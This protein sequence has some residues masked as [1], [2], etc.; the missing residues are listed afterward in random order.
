MTT[1]Q[2]HEPHVPAS[3]RPRRHRTRRRVLVLG[4]CVLVLPILLFL[5]LTHSPLTSA[6]VS[7]ILQN[8]TGAEVSV[9]DARIGIRGKATLR[10]VAATAPGLRG[11]A[12]TFVQ[13]ERIVAEFSWLDLL[14]GRGVRAITL[15][16][17]RLRL[18]QSTETQLLNV[19]ALTLLRP[20]SSG[21]AGLPTVIVD[22]ASLEIGEHT[23]ADYNPLSVIHFDGAVIPDP[24]APNNASTIR[25]S[26][27]A[28]EGPILGVPGQDIIGRIDNDAVTITPTE[29]SL[30]SLRPSSLPASAR[31]ELELLDLKGRL[32]L[33]AFTYTFASGRVEAEIVLRGVEMNL[34]IQPVGPDHPDTP[35]RLS[36]VN[37]TVG[38]RSDGILAD[39]KG[40]VADLPYTVR[41]NYMGSTA[42][43]PFTCELATDGYQV[44]SR[45]DLLPFAPAVVRERLDTFSNPTATVSTHLTISRDLP[46]PD[47]PSP[48]RVRGT[49]DFKD[50]TASYHEFPYVF[51]QMT[52][53]VT[54]DDEKIVLNSV[55]GV[56]DSG[57]RIHVTGTVAPPTELATV[58]IVARVTNVP[59]DQAIANAL[60]PE[61]DE[62]IS[63]LFSEGRH[64]QLVESGLVLGAEQ[65]ARLKDD[66][67]RLRAMPVRSPEADARLAAVEQTLARTPAF[68]PGG[69]ADVLVHVTRPY[70]YL[71]PWK[72]DVIVTFVSLGVLPEAF[73][74]PIIASDVRLHITDDHA[75]LE[76]GTYRTPRGG[77]AT[78][79][80]TVDL[81]APDGSRDFLPRIEIVA[82]SIPVDD[83]LIHAIPDRS[84][85][86]DSN[87]SAREALTALDIDG[88]IDI[89]AKI[90]PRA[91]GSLGYAVDAD[92]P[93]LRAAP[94]G[95]PDGPAIFLD[96]VRG[97]LSISD[98][99]L[100][101]S[102]QASLSAA[103][104]AERP[105]DISP[106]GAASVDLGV[107]LGDRTGSTLTASVTDLNAAAPIED[108]IRPFSPAA[109]ERLAS[110]R[111]AHQPK[112]TLDVSITAQAS[113]DASRAVVTARNIRDAS[114]DAL[115]GRVSLS[116]V[117][118]EVVADLDAPRGNGATIGFRDFVGAIDH[119]AMSAGRIALGGQ[120]H[121]GA[122]AIDPSR[123]DLSIEWTDAPL[124]SDAVRSLLRQSVGET[125]HSLYAEHD[126][127][128]RFDLDLRLSPA[129]RR[130]QDPPDAPPTL[131]A[132]GS[133][134]PRTISVVRYGTR[135]EFPSASG[136]IRFSP[137]G[138]TFDRLSLNAPGISLSLDGWWRLA[139]PGEGHT[140]ELTFNGWAT[141]QGR[142]VSSLLPA[143]LHEMAESAEFAVDGDL[144]LDDVRL[145]V[146]GDPRSPDAD[147]RATGAISLERASMRLGL[148][149]T[150]LSGV[151]RFM[152]GTEAGSPTFDVGLI[153][154][155]L[156]LANL[157]IT[158]ARV[159]VASDPS[160]PRVIVP[161]ISGNAHGGRLSGRAII[162]PTSDNAATRDFYASLHVAGARFA[163]VLADIAPG[164]ATT[165]S[166]PDASRGLL[167]AEFTMRGI[168][169]RPETT[170]GR[171]EF[172]VSGGKVL[173]L[174]LLLPI[175]Q[176]TSL[177]VPTAEP[178][179]LALASFHLSDGRVVFEEMSVFSRSVELFG[180]GTMSWPDS[181][182]DLRIISRAARSLPI[183]SSI[184]ET[185][186]NELVSVRV[187]GTL[188]KPDV[189]LSQFSTTRDVIRRILGASPTEQ[190]RQM[191][192]IRLRAYADQ[193]RVRRAGERI[194][195]IANAPAI[196]GE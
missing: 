188:T 133:L 138:G 124:D 3:N 117:E 30:N 185:I 173:S 148:P 182:L 163:S 130:P 187:G 106:A 4:V 121:I 174:P 26:T 123:T 47:G 91:D 186:R 98:Q 104:D 169:G 19:S 99:A 69:K 2:P 167:D 191:E 54:F 97:T 142:A 144:R 67:D 50:G 41:L 183:V 63:A 60:G 136:A 109:A 195:G 132:T 158:D 139:A 44:S 74:L 126:P 68:D 134:R 81:F 116:V 111:E 146:R 59:V 170:V 110:I 140:M 161:L 70:G 95:A 193:D 180:Y 76:R 179:D 105:T 196:K 40:R 128:G 157:R 8:L 78:V 154:P 58:D 120:V 194:Q 143:R 168:V 85:P 177:Q 184:I 101:A 84:G 175:I 48:V 43:A 25:I 18:S 189:S 80:C 155:S 7:P 28:P 6:I 10:G 83:L 178:L 171:G 62:V 65:A 90:E 149:I 55:E 13:V 162:G 150:N 118:G 147:I 129:A 165:P 35:L 103:L 172:A 119:D 75:V 107:L 79:D 153:S 71:T 94:I 77:L 190:A 137:E 92:L 31:R 39:L 29:L 22:D 51:R 27:L 36:A 61:R 122:D 135:V 52:G 125:A 15:L 192:Q 160:D 21:A 96:Q 89:R 108:A 115:G 57:A 33:R 152:A 88:V 46:T 93:G 159:R 38:L 100:D 127:I 14:R 145:S 131:G 64:R 181:S 24:A 66:M 114:F 45:P 73:P 176:V 20:A 141:E 151:V 37:G 9:R 164:A 12:A 42:D 1:A 16:E 82:G 53:S 113:G 23:G 86:S 166:E 156:D 102:I 11:P 49:L 112:A 34:P 56:A 87:P 17:P 32:R 5:L 72:T